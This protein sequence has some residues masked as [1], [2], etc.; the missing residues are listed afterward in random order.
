MVLHGWTHKV[1]IFRASRERKHDLHS[2]LTTEDIYGADQ[3]A[4]IVESEAEYIADL[5]GV[6]GIT[7]HPARIIVPDS[8][9]LDEGYLLEVKK[10]MVLDGAWQAV[11]ATTT[12]ALSVG[13]TSVPLTRTIGFG[14]GDQVLVKDGSGEE[15]TKVKT[16]GATSLTLYA[17]VALES[18]YASGATVRAA[19]YFQ[20][21]AV[22]WPHEVAGHR[23]ADIQEILKVVS[24]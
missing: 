17:D 22:K 23:E 13:A 21:V 20:V 4:I 3:N 8:I 9:D 6:G 1:R 11:E 16:V 24:S 10:P 12:A 14:V 2:V 7:R 18:G 19:R 15:L 5:A